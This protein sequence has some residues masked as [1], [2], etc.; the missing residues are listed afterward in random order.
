M[1]QSCIELLQFAF[2]VLELNKVE[3]HCAVGNMR[4]RAIPQRLHFTQEGVIRQAEWLYDHYTD[5]ILYGL[6]TSEWKH[7]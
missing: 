3:I 1:T 6:L 2:S 4:S 5:L 7:A